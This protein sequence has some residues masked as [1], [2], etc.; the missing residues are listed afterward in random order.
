LAATVIAAVQMRKAGWNAGGNTLELQFPA[1]A[2]YFLS[3]AD[4]LFWS[5]R[6][7]GC[8]PLLLSHFRF[9]G[10]V[11]AFFLSDFNDGESSR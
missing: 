9:P 2:S 5:E 10:S 8:F 6:K 4:D 11:I 7:T 3:T 1:V